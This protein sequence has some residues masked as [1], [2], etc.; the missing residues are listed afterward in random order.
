VREEQRV[1]FMVQPTFSPQSF[2]SEAAA[3][4]AVEAAFP[5]RERAAFERDALFPLAGIDAKKAVR[6][7]RIERL[8][9]QL[10][11]AEP[12]I[13]RDFLDGRLEFVRAARALEEQALMAGSEDALKYINEYRSYM[14]TYTFGRD[15][16]AQV[17]DRRT[18][19]EVSEEVR[20]QR[21]LRVMT[22][23]EPIEP[24]P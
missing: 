18:E 7:C 15:L 12:A 4:F 17:V 5:P 11:T 8:V 19:G 3:T 9:D 1:E 16:V 21:Y 13:A 2:A 10:H 6:Y 22:S 14:A 23:V 24:Q 20:W